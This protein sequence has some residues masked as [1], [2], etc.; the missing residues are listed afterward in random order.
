MYNNACRVA[1]AAETHAVV[2][3]S[4][5]PGLADLLTET[6]WKVHLDGEFKKPYF[7]KLEKFLKTEWATQ[8]IFPPKEAI[9]RSGHEVTKLH[10]L[11][12][13]RNQHTHATADA[14]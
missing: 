2:S 10:R 13:S 3:A 1:C 4:G 5:Q 11:H 7:H 12:S 8:Q 6:S 14:G 9:F